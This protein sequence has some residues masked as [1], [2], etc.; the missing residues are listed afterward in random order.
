LEGAIPRT[1][2]FRLLPSDRF[3]NFLPGRLWFAPTKS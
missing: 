3:K 1:S 2:F